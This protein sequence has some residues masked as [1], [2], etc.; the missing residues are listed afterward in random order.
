MT[1]FI[2]NLLKQVPGARWIVN[3]L[4]LAK[5]HPQTEPIQ[6]GEAGIRQV[7]HRNYVGG[8][9]EEIGK[10]QF[11][12]LISQGLRPHHY[13]CDVACGSLRAGIHFIRYLD[14]GHYLGI[15]KEQ[16][17]ITAGI[18]KELGEELNTAKQPQFVVSSEFEFEHFSN[19][20]HFTLAQSLFTHL[21]PRYIE[22]C[23]EK[24]RAWIVPGGVFYA[25]YFLTEAEIVNEDNPHDYRA[26]LYTKRQM[27]AF[28]E[29]RGWKAEYI[30]NW[31]HPRG[32]V[33]VKYTPC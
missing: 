8:C 15:D 9:W 16:S 3:K 25:T 12:Y 33:M 28:G 22:N 1:R 31:K 17:L 5:Q 24:L 18:E 13:L 23:F 30:G 27:E 21:P 6:H 10:L 2:R 32:Q 14:R 7:G 11:D 4:G 19:R 26:F 20:P 29:S